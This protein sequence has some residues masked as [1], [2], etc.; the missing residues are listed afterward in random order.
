M[1]T[2]LTLPQEDVT[3]RCVTSPPFSSTS[4]KPHVLQREG[5]RGRGKG[6]EGGRERGGE[7]GREGEGRGGREEVSNILRG[8]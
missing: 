3:G 2:A 6:G 8:Y 4:L 1:T 5:G 7:G